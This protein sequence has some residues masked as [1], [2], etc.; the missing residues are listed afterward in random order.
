[1]YIE[2]LMLVYSSLNSAYHINNRSEKMSTIFLAKTLCVSNYCIEF[3]KCMYH[4]DKN[5]ICMRGNF[6][7]SSS[8]SN[9]TNH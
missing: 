3:R 7:G 4:N 1:M 8:D 2:S 5:L 6:T 9:P